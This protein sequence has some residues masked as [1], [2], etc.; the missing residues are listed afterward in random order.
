MSLRT[1]AIHCVSKCILLHLVSSNFFFHLEKKKKNKIKPCWITFSSWWSMIFVWERR[2]KKIP[3]TI[4]YMMKCTN[5]CECVLQMQRFIFIGHDMFVKK[6]TKTGGVNP[7]LQSYRLL[8]IFFI[9][10]FFFFVL[11]HHIENE[12]KI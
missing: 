7:L 9:L 4:Y 3:R 11:S 1:C 12:K 10:F 8:L 5:D 2:R 6:K